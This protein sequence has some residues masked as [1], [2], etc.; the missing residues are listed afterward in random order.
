MNYYFLSNLLNQIYHLKI[1]LLFKLVS[2]NQA[3]NYCHSFIQ[4]TKELLKEYIFHDP[5]DKASLECDEKT[6]EVKVCDWKMLKMVCKI[7]FSWNYLDWTTN[8]I[9]WSFCM[10]VLWMGIPSQ[11][12]AYCTHK[13]R[14]KFLKQ[15]WEGW[16]VSIEREQLEI[17]RTKVVKL[18]F[19]ID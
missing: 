16:L 9:C 19:L 10:G 11:L 17:Q 2:I 12:L 5:N 3:K 8:R 7:T 4:V 18:I 13:P 14:A 1:Q 15:N 6:K